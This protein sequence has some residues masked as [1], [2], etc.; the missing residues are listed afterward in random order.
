METFIDRDPAEAV[1]ESIDQVPP[2]PPEI[3]Q[4]VGVDEPDSKEPL[5]IRLDV[6]AASSRTKNP[7][8]IALA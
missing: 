8:A 7:D 5:A 4:L 6:V 3:V 2:V 1:E